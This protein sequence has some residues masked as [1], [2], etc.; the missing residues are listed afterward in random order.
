[1]KTRS[2]PDLSMKPV[3]AKVSYSN[4]TLAGANTMSR[5]ALAQVDGLTWARRAAERR[6][7]SRRLDTTQPSEVRYTGT[8]CRSCRSTPVGLVAC[9]RSR[10]PSGRLHLPGAGTK[11]DMSG[12][13]GCGRSSDHTCELGVD[14][15]RS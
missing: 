8:R 2:S 7:I 13:W 5:P 10:S 9:I 12:C 11:I 14:S 15:P 1:M 4:F 3:D 6:R